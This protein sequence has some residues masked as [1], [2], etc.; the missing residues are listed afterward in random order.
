MLF[1]AVTLGFFVENKREHF[2]EHKR[3]VEYALS[4]LNDLKGDTTELRMLGE[5]Y[6]FGA[7]C[8]DTFINI[9]AKNDLHKVPGGKLYWYGL[10][11][12]FMHPF[13][14]N[15]ATFQQM[16]SSGS[17]RYITNKDLV[18]KIS[19]YDWQVRKINSYLD[20]DQSIYTET[21]KAR[22]KIFDFRYNITC[23]EIAQAL[24]I[25]M[26]SHEPFNR[27][28]LDSFM[29][30]ELPLLTYDKNILNQYT[31]MCRSRSLGILSIN[32]NIA[33]SL[34]RELAGDLKK[35][36]HLD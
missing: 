32:L 29:A 24:Y 12:G 8:L 33:L 31:E 34:A 13:I 28:R 20:R 15:D 36:Y 25:S 4:M 30:S 23:N 5:R 7:A 3:A 22:A 18:D 21:R 10:W 17:L 14:T 2:I 11:G 27:Q 16:K 6:S 19:L 9:V 1:L 26:S 35:E